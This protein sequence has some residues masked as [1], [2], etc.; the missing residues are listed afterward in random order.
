MC[1]STR[2]DAAI[3]VSLRTDF[4][5]ASIFINVSIETV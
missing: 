3:T 5:I 4:V 1:R 2:Y